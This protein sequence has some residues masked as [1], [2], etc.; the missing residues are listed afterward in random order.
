MRVRAAAGDHAHG[1][2]VDR[3]LAV[4]G[5][6][7]AL[8]LADDLAGHA[9]DV[10]VGQ[11]GA[12]RQGGEHE[13]GEVVAGGD[14]GHAVGCPDLE[15]AHAPPPRRAPPRPPPSRRSRRGRSSSAAPPARGARPPRAGRPGRRRG[16][17][18]ASRRA[19]RRRTGRRSG[20]RPPPALTSTPMLASICAAMPCTWRAADDGGEADDGRRRR[21]HGVADAR[22]RRG[23]CRPRRRGWTAAAPRGRSSA[24]ASSTPGAGVAAS[25]PTTSTASA[26]TAARS[27]TQY[28][29][30]WTTR[31]PLGLSGS[32]IAMCVSTR[33]SL[34]G[35]R[36]ARRAAS[37]GTAP[38]SP[39][40]A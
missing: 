18:P 35:S 6:G 5:A 31:R 15:P 20:R 1:L 22:A 7:P 21:A 17:R 8:G 26:G 36:R 40:R 3:R 2:L 29:W 12:V 24:M 13:A 25:W 19:R 11:V 30:K 10:A 14:L 27:R 34:I 16:C 9:H 32:A 37:A 28:S 38:R 39:A 23:W 4:A 33:S